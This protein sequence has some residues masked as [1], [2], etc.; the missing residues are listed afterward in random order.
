MKL[1]LSLFLITQYDQKPNL[2]T[3]VLVGS[4][5]CLL[6]MACSYVNTNVNTVVLR[7]LYRIYLVSAV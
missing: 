4:G 7:K 1:Y 3:L 6:N 2:K 5:L